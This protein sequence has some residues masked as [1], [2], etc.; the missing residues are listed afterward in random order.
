MPNL[1]RLAR[2][3]TLHH[4]LE[5]AVRVTEELAANESMVRLAAA[6]PDRWNFVLDSLSAAMESGEMGSLRQVC[7]ALGVA[8]ED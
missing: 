6:D 5:T 4:S 1:P 3:Q 8:L 7:T 2:L